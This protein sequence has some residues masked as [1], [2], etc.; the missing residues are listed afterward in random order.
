MVNHTTQT[1]LPRAALSAEAKRKEGQ[2]LN[3]G[4]QITAALPNILTTSLK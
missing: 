3:K 4:L 2:F 1:W